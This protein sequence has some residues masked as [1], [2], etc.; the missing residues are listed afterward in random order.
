MVMYTGRQPGLRW[1][2]DGNFEVV[3]GAIVRLAILPEMAVLEGEL[4]RR[5]CLAYGS[6]A[7]LP[8]ESYPATIWRLYNFLPGDCC[9][10]DTSSGIRFD[11]PTAHVHLKE[12]YPSLLGG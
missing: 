10:R 6:V 11:G 4:A 3:R 2:F 8:A 12:R 9:H 7:S 5:M 1:W